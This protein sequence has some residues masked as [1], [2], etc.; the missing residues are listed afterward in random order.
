MKK[1]I[2]GILEA[3]R[4]GINSGIAEGF[5]SMIRAGFKRAFGFKSHEYRATI[6]Y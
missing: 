6:I 5:N 3:I 2:E 4:S 1:H